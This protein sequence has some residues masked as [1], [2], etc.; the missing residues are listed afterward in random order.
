MR[1]L[2]TAAPAA[3]PA[4]FNNIA[5]ERSIVFSTVGDK[6][7]RLDAYWHKKRLRRPAAPIFMYIHGMST[8]GSAILMMHGAPHT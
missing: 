1:W 8:H 4:M 3:F 7:L 6:R 5:I 2:L